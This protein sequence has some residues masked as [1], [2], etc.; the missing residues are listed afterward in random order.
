MSEKST[1]IVHS[2]DVA[3]DST[4]EIDSLTL[5]N[6]GVLLLTPMQCSAAAAN[7]IV[8][9]VLS[10]FIFRDVKRA[11]YRLFIKVSETFIFTLSRI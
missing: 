1:C 5:T 7:P 2:F 4:F 6:I 3:N 8:S 9:F 10:S 11:L